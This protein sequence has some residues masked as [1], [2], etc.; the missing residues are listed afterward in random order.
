MTSLKRWLSGA[1]LLLFF[2]C[3]LVIAWNIPY[4]HDDWDW[5]LEKSWELWRSGAMNSR[6]GGSFFVLTMTRSP[7][8]KTLVMGSVLFLLPLLC[9]L[10][11]SPGRRDARFPLALLAGAAL[12]AM[13]MLSWRQTFGWVSAFANFVVAAVFLLLVLLLWQ[14][15]FSAPLSRV[16]GTKLGAALF[17]LC[18]AAQLFAEHLTL[19][20]L[21]AA[22]VCAGWA[23]WKKTAR[24]PILCSLAGCLLGAVLMFHNPLYGELAAS[25]QAVDGIR[26][27]VAEPGQGLFTAAL[28]RFFGEVLPWLFECFPGAAALASAGCLWRLIRR[29]TPWFLT[30]PAGLWMAYYCAQ[31]WLYLNQLHLWGE[32]TYPWPL[33]RGPGAAIQLALM[34]AVLLTAREKSRPTWLLLLAAAVGLLAPFALLRDSGAR[35][36]FLSAVVLMVLGASLL[37]DLPWSPLLQGAALV[38]LAA[39]LV[40]HLHAYA[41]I[42]R[43]EAIR[44]DQMA[45]AVAQGADQVVLP[46][47]GWAYCYCWQRNPSQMRA[48]YFRQFYGLPAD[49][50]LVFLPRGSSELWPEVPEAMWAGAVY[51]PPTES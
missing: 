7:L 33:L 50:E 51:L 35:C 20:L 19:I 16:Q 38:G 32:W 3:C 9:G 30:I 44:Q 2:L 10:L 6:Y 24:L 43:S 49:M 28:K 8:F 39:G 34:A 42:G 29:R 5:G 46:T 47:E 21:C 14:R 25:G 48:D 17:L 37:S 40:F 45:Q 11:A 41:A 26:N 36:A 13:P 15:S 12:F 23:L 27:L 22:L 4:T 18:L 31:N 1:A